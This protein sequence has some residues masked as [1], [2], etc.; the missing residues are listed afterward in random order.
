MFITSSC[1]WLL[2]SYVDEIECLDTDKNSLCQPRP[3]IGFFTI[4][5]GKPNTYMQQNLKMIIVLGV[6]LLFQ[7]SCRWLLWSYL[8]EILRL[9]KDKTG[10]VN[11][12]LMIHNLLFLKD[13]KYPLTAESK[14]S[15]S[16]QQKAYS[17]KLTAES[18][19]IKTR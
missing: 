13:T 3:S 16:I 12:V 4:F 10:Y 14:S 15:K 11:K 19:S 9:D 2:W 5:G 6:Y 1:G 17:R 8:V 18:T 7:G